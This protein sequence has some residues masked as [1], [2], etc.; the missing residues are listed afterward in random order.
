MNRSS[1][2]SSLVRRPQS[3]RKSLKLGVIAILAIAIASNIAILGNLGA[4][5]GYPV[6][7]AANQDL[8][9]PYFS[10]VNLNSAPDN[11]FGIFRPVYNN[12]ADLL[13]SRADCAIYQLGGGVV[14]QGSS[15][16]MLYYLYVTPSLAKALG[17]NVIA[18]RSLRPM[19]EVPG[20]APVIVVS[21]NLARNRFGSYDAALNHE[22]WISDKS[23]RIVGVLPA[24][25]EFPSKRIFGN[26]TP[27]AWI[28]F[29]PESAGA[30][31]HLD[32]GMYSIVHLHSGVSVSMLSAAFTE[33][34]KQALPM[35][36]NDMRAYMQNIQL[37]QRI[38]S[39]AQ[40]QYGRVL[41]RLQLLE[42]AAFLLFVLVVIN[43]IGLTTSDVI[44]RRHEFATRAVLG[45]SGLQIYCQRFYL[46]LR[47][48]LVGWLI[49]VAMGWAWQRWLA[50]I[51]GQAGASV[52]LSAP[53]LL[54]SF[55]FMLV[56]VIMLSAIGVL[57]IIK[58][59][60]LVVDL[61]SNMHVTGSRKMV[62]VMQFLI[63]MQLAASA[64][65]LILAGNFYENVFVLTHNNLGFS[66]SDRSYFTVLLPGEEGSQVMQFDQNFLNLL[67]NH[68]GIEGAAKFSVIPF[69][70]GDSST[71]AW[72]VGKEADSKSINEQV[73]S[74]RFVQAMGL[75]IL[76]GNPRDIFTGNDNSIF[77]DQT[78][79]ENFWPS[80][81][82]SEIIGKNLYFG[83][84]QPG[85][86]RVAAVIA[87]MRI[88]PYESIGGTFFIS[89]KLDSFNR[90]P[91]NFVVHSS[92]SPDL[93]HKAIVKYV[94]K[95]NPQAMIL[96]SK[97]ASSVVNEAYGGR[98]LLGRIFGVLAIMA[99]M[100]SA[101]GLF[102]LLDYRSLVRRPEFAIRSAL[103]ATPGRLFSKVLA[104]AGVMLMIGC[105]IG[106]P[107]AYGITVI[108]GNYFP[109]LGLPTFWIT[110]DSMAIMGIIVILSAIVPARRAASIYLSE[111][112]SV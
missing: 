48:G 14:R 6:P 91:Q 98:V 83:L 28:P 57:R 12:L 112:L 29:P 103:G 84:R 49:G 88:K 26:D 106:V 108:L 16:A 10:A 89:T 32:R 70:R 61:S 11:A 8:Y 62:R 45:A 23:Y 100:I 52:A 40:R 93:L 51:I 58:P 110:I 69:S 64:T 50:G 109:Q 38:S 22:L 33:A 31:G 107:V 99:L 34:Y 3:R 97:S 20:A 78:A 67:N 82:A 87:P 85:P 44:S 74:E 27:E 75:K 71:D 53:V 55:G 96:F 72:V 60:N 17:V 90:G 7:G 76:A 36:S 63:A 43:L 47:L 56:V 81:K 39:F 102:A 35:Y 15:N 4:I 30:I 105:V 59:K 86:Y 73:I 19:D 2:M 54:I 111:N 104:E 77:I 24:D 41:T 66:A 79:A 5:F 68:T 95:V 18:G 21:A 25:L 80:L 65:L 13:S 101:V 46:F 9:E 92:L 1:Q 42:L 94:Y 37:V